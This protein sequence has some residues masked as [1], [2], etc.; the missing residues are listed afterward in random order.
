MPSTGR[1]TKATNEVEQLNRELEHAHKL[2]LLGTLAAGIAHEVNNILTPAMSYLDIAA[3]DFDDQAKVSRAI[4]FSGTAIRRVAE[5]S[6]AILELGR[7]GDS[8]VLHVEPPR[9]ASCNVSGAV[10]QAILCMGKADDGRVEADI[11]AD[12][13]AAIRPIALEQVMLNLLIN[14]SEALGDA[15]RIRVTAWRTIRTD[16]RDR[17]EIEVQD[18]GRGISDEDLKSIFRSFVSHSTRHGS[19]GLGLMVCQRLVESA[20]GSIKVQS[21]VG[22]GTTFRLNLPSAEAS[23]RKSA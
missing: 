14:A 12:L 13:F 17:I 9:H 19:S 8:D 21:T 3:A 5:I 6:E 2:A 11:P 18:N 10:S 23:L 15:G 22:E 16:E 20:G 7:A 4:T 1:D